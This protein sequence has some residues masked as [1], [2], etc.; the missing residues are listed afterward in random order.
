MGRLV[1]S[2]QG[3]ARF[4]FA[5]THFAGLILL[6]FLSASC[7][8]RSTEVS[9]PPKKIW[10]EFSGERALTHV[11]A[12]VDFGPRPPGSEAIEK[13]RN[14]LAQQLELSGW[15]VTRQAFTDNTPQG[16]IEFVNLIATF[17]G[18]DNTQSFLVCSH[19]DTKIF[20][21]VTFVGAND[22]GSST[23]LLVE[24]A[25]VL[26]LRPEV[27]RKVELLFFDGEEAFEAFSD[28]DGFYGSRYFAKQLVAEGKIKQF[29]GGVVVD[30]I[31]DRA[32][33][34]TLPPDSPPEMADDIFKSAEALNLRNYF[35]Y[36]DRAISDDHT[37]L[38]AAGIPA[39]D[40]IDFD[41][42]AWHTAE[43]TMDKISAESLQKVGSV[44]GYYLAEIALKKPS[45]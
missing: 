33:T 36:F 21:T 9:A 32:L 15:K 43:D 29:R 28:T 3:H 18:K 2:R 37:P 35:T 12:M 10:E 1:R 44:V 42:P 40:L 5:A 24:L 41:Y 19:Y 13:T 27:A 8:S 39:I 25:R 17:G 14:Y 23:G 20:K 34:I 6:S 16:K 30:M 45:N 7:D 31:G 38:N 4:V 22:A 11:Q 26:S